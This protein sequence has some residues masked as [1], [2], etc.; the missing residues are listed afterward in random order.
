MMRNRSKSRFSKRGRLTRGVSGAV[1]EVDVGLDAP[2]LLLLLL[3]VD[4]TL[5]SAVDVGE[6][7]PDGAVMLLKT[8][9]VALLAVVVD[10][11]AEAISGQLLLIAVLLLPLLL[12][13]PEL[14]TAVTAVAAA[15]LAATAAALARF[16]GLP[17]GGWSLGAAMAAAASAATLLVTA[18]LLLL[19]LLARRR[20]SLDERNTGPRADLYLD[21]RR[22]ERTDRI[23]HG[24]LGTTIDICECAADIIECKKSICGR[25][26]RRSAS[27][28]RKASLTRAY[29]NGISY[30]SEFL[31]G[32]ASTHGNPPRRNTHDM[33]PRMLCVM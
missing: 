20:R 8:S 7:Q 18:L 25:T 10:V 23:R 22:N 15:A 30:V 2:P 33:Y 32:N 19:L 14:A 27:L 3:V 31:L 13:Q 11:A 21:D 26:V 4:D 9:V 5:L 12:L 28:V 1:V 6:L 29:T 16:G 17:C 24:L